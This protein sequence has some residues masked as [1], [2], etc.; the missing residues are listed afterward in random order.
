LSGLADEHEA[1]PDIT[2]HGADVQSS[3]IV[4]RRFHVEHVRR[5]IGDHV[6]TLVDVDASR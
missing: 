5:R 1:H 2:L 6:Y 3:V 4:Q